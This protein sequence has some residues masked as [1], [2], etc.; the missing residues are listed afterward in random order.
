MGAAVRLVVPILACRDLTETIRFY[1][2]YLGFEQQW[3]WGEPATDGGVKRG[4][5]QIFFMTDADLAVRAI[6]SEVMLFVDDVDALYAEH[7][8]RGA[9]ISDPIADEPWNLR[10]YKVRDLHG[11]VL[12][13]AESSEAVAARHAERAG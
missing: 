2:R 9:P 6:G 1:V 10:E 12:R 7:Q 4:D 11:Y 8:Q 3:T 13:F 5:V